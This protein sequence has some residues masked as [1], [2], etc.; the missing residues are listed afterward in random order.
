MKTG[1]IIKLGQHRLICGDCKDPAIIKKLV[2]QDQIRVVLTDP[3][4]GVGYVENK[5]W[6]GMRGTESKHFNQHKKIAGDQLQT[7]DGYAKFTKE[8]IEPA[9]K[10]LKSYKIL[11]DFRLTP[12]K[13]VIRTIN[14][15]ESDRVHRDL[16]GAYGSSVDVIA[17]KNLINYLCELFKSCVY[18]SINLLIEN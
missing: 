8:W 16:G 7:D 6:L 3:P 5:D 9:I 17:Y 15:K 11:K 14:H 13:R 1:E 2:G 4:Y 18:N 12:R 10:Y